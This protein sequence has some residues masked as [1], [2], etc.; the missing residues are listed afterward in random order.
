M[1]KSHKIILGSL[2]IASGIL[3]VT[4]DW[5]RNKYKR[6]FDNMTYMIG[7]I[8][9]FDISL[10]RVRFSLTVLLKNN[11]NESINVSTFGV[12]VLEKVVVTDNL[13]NVVGDVNTVF[14]S[15]KIS[16]YE[17]VELPKLT[18]EIPLLQAL[19]TISNTEFS[20]LSPD[21]ILQKFKFTLHF[22]LAGK[23]LEY[24][25]K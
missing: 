4:G 14:D 24:T 19:K 17:L 11:T 9:N 25:L 10:K 15:F 16:E 6:L 23:P 12:A 22:R 13:G 18:F 8:S 21:K 5:A 2:V 20:T 1:K 7:S 3:L